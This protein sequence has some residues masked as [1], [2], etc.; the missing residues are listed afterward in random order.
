M[1]AK[2]FTSDTG[3]FKLTLP[4]NWDQYD[5]EGEEGTYGFFNSHTKHWTGNLRVTPLKLS[6]VVDDNN[7]K[8]ADHIDKE[9]AAHH[10]ATR[11]SI[12]GFDCAHYKVYGKDENDQ[13]LLYYWIMG[14][15]DFLFVC[16][17]TINKADELTKESTSELNNVQGIIQSIQII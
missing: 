2:I 11:I 12:A 1:T 7:G 5:L 3:W 8:I 10:G 15:K 17:F 13:F 16:S 6:L 14:Q 4:S 9:I